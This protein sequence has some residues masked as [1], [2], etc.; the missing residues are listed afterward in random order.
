MTQYFS[1][2]TPNSFAYQLCVYRNYIIV[3][4]KQEFRVSVQSYLHLLEC[5]LFLFVVPEHC[6]KKLRS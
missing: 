5:T 6:A 2:S 3:A 1:V 4:E